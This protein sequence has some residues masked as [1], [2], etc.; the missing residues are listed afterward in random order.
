MVRVKEIFGQDKILVISQKFHNERAIYIA[1]QLRLKAIGFNAQDVQKYYGIK[2]SIR[3]KFARVKVV[4]D[5]W[6]GVK[7][8]FLGEKIRMK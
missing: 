3:E 4:L 7:P 8:K 2:T 5:F 6:L 1:E